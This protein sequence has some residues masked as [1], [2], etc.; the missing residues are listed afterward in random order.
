MTIYSQISGNR[1]KTFMIMGLFIALVTGLFYAIG[2]YYNIGDGF[3]VMGFIFSIFS[4]IGSYYFSDKMVLGLTGAHLASKEKY[5][6]LYTAVENMS[7]ASGVPMP[8]VYVINSDQLNAFATGRDPKHG[9]VVA[10]TGILNRLDRS[11]LEGVIAHEMSHIKNYDILLSS[12]VA[13]LVGT[14]ALITDWVLRWRWF[15]GR[16]KEEK[17]SPAMTILFIIAL[18][19]SPIVA[20]LIQLAISRQREYLADASSA[21][22]TRNPDGLASALEKISSFNKQPM[23]VPSTVSHLFIANPL[24]T[25]GKERSNFLAN[26]FSTHPPIQERIK[27]LRD[28]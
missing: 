25:E 11:E 5:F 27:I 7:I 12:V 2:Y 19:L 17:Q 1:F 18:I 3:L 10:T 4:T 15:G 24:K 28:M 26:L 16:D 6:N 21:L 13:V 22:L 14:V 9:V 8:R 23:H 20:T